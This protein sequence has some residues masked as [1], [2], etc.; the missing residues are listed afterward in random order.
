MGKNKEIW[1]HL[2]VTV[3][4][5]LLVAFLRGKVD[6]GLLGLGLGAFGGIFLLDVDHFFY[7]FLTN[8]D[9]EDSQAA[10]KIWETRGKGFS[11]FRQ[12]FKK[13]W[14]LLSENHKTHTRLVFHSLLGQ[15]VM[16]IL[17]IFV[18][19]SSGSIFGSALILS[20]NLHLLKDEWEDFFRD[21]EHLADWLFWQVR[22]PKLKEHLGVYLGAVTLIFL[23]LT[24]FLI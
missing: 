20:L 9:K 22:E 18:V 8:T 1:S 14:E 17:A 10:K 7:W 3:V 11:G 6:W 15:I 4:W 12:S 5:F 21:K 24:G 2:L 19:T 13:L 23:L 16:L